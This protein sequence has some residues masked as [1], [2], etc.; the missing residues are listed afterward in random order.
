MPVVANGCSDYR[1][2]KPVNWRLSTFDWDMVDAQV[3]PL[4]SESQWNLFTTVAAHP[5]WDR[6][7]SRVQGAMAKALQAEAAARATQSADFK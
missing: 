6:S 5:G 2:G 1:S 3:R 7:S 4:M